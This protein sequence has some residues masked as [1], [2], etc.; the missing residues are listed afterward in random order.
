MSVAVNLSKGGAVDLGKSNPGLTKV[1]AGLGWD[2][3]TGNVEFDLDASAF[4]LGSNGKVSSDSDF[5][6]YNNKFSADGAVQGA[7]D[8]RSGGNSDGGDDETIQIDLSKVSS[9]VQRIAITVT[10]NDADVRGQN[11]GQVKNSY[12]RVV[13]ATNNSEILRYDLSGDFS[14]NDAVI[15]G[16]FSR[17]GS[18]WEFKAIGEGRTGG[19]LTLCKE[20]GINV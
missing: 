4:L 2:P 8:D 6:F 10:I 20:Y 14:K 3:A 11:F 1:E 5:V 18:G 12:V 15:F 19:L 9:S 7:D 17:T 16:E 13:N